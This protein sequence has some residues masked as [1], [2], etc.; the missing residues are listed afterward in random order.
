V[1]SVKKFRT[2]KDWMNLSYPMLAMNHDEYAPYIKAFKESFPAGIFTVRKTEKKIILESEDTYAMFAPQCFYLE[3]RGLWFSRHTENQLATIREL[4]IAISNKF[5]EIEKDKKDFESLLTISQIDVCT[6]YL[7]I[8][9]AQIVAPFFNPANKPCFQCEK[10]R[11]IDKYDIETSV[12]FFTSK[13]KLRVYD[14]IR[15]NKK[16]KNKEKK[17]YYETL[18]PK[19]VDVCRVE[20]SISGTPECKDFTYLLY[21]KATYDKTNPDEYFCSYVLKYWWKNHR[22]RVIDPMIQMNL[23]GSMKNNG[24]RCLIILS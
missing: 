19:D 9:P 6:D 3:I 4:A 1:K 15:E 13:W 22:V 17:K 5:N 20:I 21:D 23:V 11:Y 7:N 8:N 2:S 14:K 12:N 18:Y 10:S 24:L 16:Q